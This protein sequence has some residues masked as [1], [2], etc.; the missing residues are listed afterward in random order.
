M[1]QFLLFI[2]IHFIFMGCTQEIELNQP[3][4]EQKVVVD[5]WIESNNFAFVVLTLSSPFLTEYDSVAI[6]KTF[7]YY[8]K[9]T[10]TNSDG[11]SE[12]LTLT[13][14]KNYFP[15]YIYQSVSI[16]GVA[17][18]TYQLKVEVL[19][20][21]ITASTTIPVPPAINR[22][23]MDA[24]TDSSGLF[25]IS[26]Q[27][28]ISQITRLFAQVKSS[29]ADKNFHPA[30]LPVFTLGATGDE[31][32]L[33]IW[34]T[35]EINLYLKANGV[36]KYAGWPKFQYA[37]TDTVRLKIGSIDEQ[38]FTVLK[39]LFDDQ[40]AKENPFAFSGLSIQSNIVGGIGRWTGIGVAPI[41][42]VHP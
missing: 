41:Q 22:V 5:G 33:S 35:R 2:T 25:M 36:D 27:P 15:P 32:K 14:N 42:T 34:R 39:S 7:L 11:K 16:K 9:I 8:A 26:L 18:K 38:S 40:I 13:R 24:K 23:W 21:T 28:N 1:K 3:E 19:N 29:R 31:Q 30:F 10:L 4:Y 37:L 20:R 6:T 12:I 17:G